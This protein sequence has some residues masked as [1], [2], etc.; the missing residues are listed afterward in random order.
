MIE[1]E[2]TRDNLSALYYL[3]TLPEVQNIPEIT[4]LREIVEEAVWADNITPE[5]GP[6]G[7]DY[8]VGTIK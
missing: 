2:L 1:L 8:I 4:E 6:N 7:P 3:V 5:V